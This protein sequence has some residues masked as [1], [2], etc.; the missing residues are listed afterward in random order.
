MFWRK[1]KRIAKLEGE[2]S[3]LRTEHA[4]KAV[5]ENR[6]MKII[7]WQQ[8]YGPAI[9]KIVAKTDPQY[10]EPE[11]DNPKRKRISDAIG[12]KAI[13]KL[14]ADHMARQHTEGK[15]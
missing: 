1:A 12:E 7:D 11:I 9:A 10:L 3:W 2:V 4:F 15:L 6:L 13:A 8:T 14:K 5:I